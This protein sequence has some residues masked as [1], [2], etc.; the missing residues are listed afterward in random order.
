M[1]ASEIR[2]C[3]LCGLRSALYL[4]VKFFLSVMTARGLSC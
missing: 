2:K 3:D 1:K 4:R